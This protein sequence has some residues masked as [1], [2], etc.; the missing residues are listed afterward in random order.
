LAFEHAEDGR[1]PRS[2]RRHAAVASPELG[3]LLRDPALADAADLHD[4]RVAEIL[5]LLD[6]L[7]AAGR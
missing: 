4:T 1:Q 3:A 2:R 6:T 5:L 7:Q